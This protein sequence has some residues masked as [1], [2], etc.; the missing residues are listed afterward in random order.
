MF[1]FNHTSIYCF[2]VLSLYSLNRF[3]HHLCKWLPS[4]HVRTS[5]LYVWRLFSM[6]TFISC[7]HARLM[8]CLM[9]LLDVCFH[10]VVSPWN[11][12]CHYLMSVFVAGQV[13][14]CHLFIHLLLKTSFF[15]WGVDLYVDTGQNILLKEI[16]CHENT[17]SK[18][19]E[20]TIPKSFFNRE[21]LKM[22]AMRQFISL[23]S[24]I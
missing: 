10:V 7:L 13:P 20:E 23:L 24:R 5:F 2:H 4:Y 11:V 8:K 16:L 22:L 18:H 3:C 19:S 17:V 6:S 21:C 1:F 12:L 9:S 14:S 15:L